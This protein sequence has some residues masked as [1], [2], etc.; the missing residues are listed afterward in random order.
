MAVGALVFR[1]GRAMVC[2][3]RTGRNNLQ[4]CLSWPLAK[5]TLFGN[6]LALGYTCPHSGVKRTCHFAMDMSAFVPDTRNQCR[7]G[8]PLTLPSELTKL[9]RSPH[10]GCA[11]T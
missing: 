11:A 5:P 6:F 1:A 9:I 2:P 8:L 4:K 3:A 7:Y 10:M